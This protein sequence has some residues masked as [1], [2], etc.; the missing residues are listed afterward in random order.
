M[1]A[2]FRGD[3]T[4]KVQLGAVASIRMGWELNWEVSPAPLLHWQWAT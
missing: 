4:A 1:E 2:L 3:T